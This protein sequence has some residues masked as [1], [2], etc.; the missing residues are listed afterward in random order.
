MRV[1]PAL[2]W[3]YTRMQQ[4]DDAVRR[5]YG[6]LATSLNEALIETRH[7][8]EPHAA[9]L[10]KGRLGEFDGLLAEF[11]RRR[12]K[13][14]VY[15]EVKAGKST[16]INALAGKELSPVAF[17]PLT[18][19]PV[20]VTYGTRTVWQVGTHRLDSIAELTQIMRAGVRDATEVVVETDADLLQLG[21]QVDLLDTP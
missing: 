16:L 10:P 9:L 19:V 2:E 4:S 15:G 6:V 7:A 20:R 5:A 13:I 12:V 21:G 3:S 17:D 8:L 14:A 11:A 18:S 1:S